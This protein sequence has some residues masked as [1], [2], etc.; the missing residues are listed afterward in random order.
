MASLT[1]RKRTFLAEREWKTVP[2]SQSE[3]SDYQCLIDLFADIPGMFETIDYIEPDGNHA[4]RF[5]ECEMLLDKVSELIGQSEAWFERWRDNHPGAAKPRRKDMQ[6]C[7]LEVLLLPPPPLDA[8]H[9][10]EFDSLVEANLF[11]LY[12]MLRILL[13]EIVVSACNLEPGLPTQSHLSEIKSIDAIDHSVNCIIASVPYHV[14]LPLPSG[15]N[16]DPAEHHAPSM[17][18]YFL[19]AP[20]RTARFPA[21]ETHRRWLDTV[22]DLIAEITH[23]PRACGDVYKCGVVGWRLAGCK[24][25]VE[26]GVTS[27]PRPQR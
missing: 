2:W 13:H 20:L 27:F 7:T 25:W 1:Q 8:A 4:S 3:K 9:E 23:V 17:G 26:Q 16:N 6:K 21:T 19:I 15:G 18:T 12:H 5:V 14:A 10:L 22:L 24:P 11:L